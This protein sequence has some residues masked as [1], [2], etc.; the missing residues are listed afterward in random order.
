MTTAIRR[1]GETPAGGSGAGR[2]CS[3]VTSDSASGQYE[4]Q[5]PEQDG[6][7]EPERPVVQVGKIVTQF[8]LRFRRVIP[9]DLSEPGHAGTHG[10]AQRISSDG[11]GEA[12]RELGPLGPRTHQAHVASKHVP[13]LGNFVEPERPQEAPDRRD[14][15]ATRSWVDAPR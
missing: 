2:A 8:D 10:M 15:L 1:R 4:R 6:E 13:E 7:S 14:A 5:G 11:A 3:G 9:G 12:L